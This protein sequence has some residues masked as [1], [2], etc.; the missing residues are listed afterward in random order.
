VKRGWWYRAYCTSIFYTF[1]TIRR[2]W[3][4]RVV[5]TCVRRT[6]WGYLNPVQC[7]GTVHLQLTHL[8]PKPVLS[9][10]ATKNRRSKSMRQEKKKVARYPFG[11]L[12][13]ASYLTIR[14]SR[15]SNIHEHKTRQPHTTSE[16]STRSPHSCSPTSCPRP[17]TTTANTTTSVLF[18]LSFSL[19]L[20]F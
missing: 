6:T 15:R 13:T 2:R 11:S 10:L 16:T 19:F 4:C 20:S 5:A 17:H 14:S 12:H 8:I 18:L 3:F 9:N 7:G 1:I